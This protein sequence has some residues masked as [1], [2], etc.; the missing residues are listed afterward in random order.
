MWPAHPC[1]VGRGHLGGKGTLAM[2]PVASRKKASLEEL[3]EQN[4]VLGVFFYKCAHA[5][6]RVPDERVAQRTSHLRA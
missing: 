1:D 2:W 3:A 6:T 4:V 5:E